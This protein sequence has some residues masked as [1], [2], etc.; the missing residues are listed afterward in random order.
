MSQ[1]RRDV[2]AV[3]QRIAGSDLAGRVN[4]WDLDGG[5]VTVRVKSDRQFLTCTI[6]YMSD[7]DYPNSPLMAMCADDDT[8]NSALESFGDH[9]EYGAPVLEVLIRLLEQVGLD[10]SPLASQ[11]ETD[12]ASGDDEDLN[13]EEDYSDTG[14]D[15]AETDN[16]VTLPYCCLQRCA[17]LC[18]VQICLHYRSY[19][20]LCSGRS[21]PGTRQKLCCKLQKT[22]LLLLLKVG[23]A[24]LACCPWRNSLPRNGRSL[25]LRRHTRCW[26]V[27]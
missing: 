23:Q 2:E 8:M 3:K 5:S 14:Q 27:S 7:S 13:S 24:Q 18:M 1:L 19:W 4:G 25:R 12:A 21:A 15:M 9:F 20:R 17:V 6:F 26:H 10:T 16:Q 11:Q 22:M